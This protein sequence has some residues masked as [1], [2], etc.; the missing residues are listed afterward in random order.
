MALYFDA[1]GHDKAFGLR[2]IL[3]Q[4]ALREPSRAEIGVFEDIRR[5]I[6]AAKNPIVVFGGK[7]NVT[8][9]PTLLALEEQ[10][11]D[12]FLVTRM[13]RFHDHSVKEDAG[14]PLRRNFVVPLYGFLYLLQNPGSARAILFYDFFLNFAWDARNAERAYAYVAALL[15]LAPSPVVLGCYDV[16][17]PVC[18]NM[19]HHEAANAFYADML[20]Q[21]G[22]I[23]LNSKS[24]HIAEYL[25]NTVAK[26][27]PVISFYRYGMPPKHRLMKLSQIDGERHIVGVTSFFGET[28][29]PN[30]AESGDFIREMLRQKIHFHYYSSNRLVFDYYGDLEESEQAYFHIHDHIWEQAQLAREMSKYDAGWLVGDEGPTFGRIVAQTEHR[31]ARDLFAL[32]VPNG[33]PTSSMAY[34]AAGLPVFASRAITIL[35]EVFPPGCLIPLDMAEVGAL[36]AILDRIDWAAVEKT[37]AENCHRFDA[38]QNISELAD[39]LEAFRGPTRHK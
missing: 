6:A 11:F 30:R 26:D 15:R 21:A 10:G 29:E 22:G 31:L 4:H 17:K 20:D 13:T 38:T 28:F 25:R 32:F 14:C 8:M 33:V 5:E 12:V 2:S 9:E 7:I 19:E 35:Q 16:I 23:W 36:P 18:L 39:Y 1:I 24:D 3:E 27:K 34:G 37:M